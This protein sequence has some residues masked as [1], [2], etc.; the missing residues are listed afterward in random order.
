MRFSKPW[1]TR[2]CKFC[3]NKEK[4]FKRFKQTKKPPDLEKYQQPA[5]NLRKACADAYNRFIHHLSEDNNKKKLFSIIISKRTE[6]T[7]V[8][9][10]KNNGTTYTK[11]ADIVTILNKQFTSVFSNDDGSIPT[12]LGE[13]ANTITS[14][15]IVTRNGVIKLLKKLKTNTAGGPDDVSAR[16]LK[17]CAMTLLMF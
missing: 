4:T 2:E 13:P 8:A 14:D 1:I 15:L 7:S 3:K 11:D 10:L 16:V 6:I 12:S 5:R 9:P 17:I